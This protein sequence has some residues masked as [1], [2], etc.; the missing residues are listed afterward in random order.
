[1]K[2]LILLATLAA[3][4]APDLLAQTTAPQRPP[5]QHERPHRHRPRARRQKSPQKD[6]RNKD[7]SGQEPGGQQFEH[8]TF[9]EDNPG[10][11][12]PRTART[13]RLQVL[14]FRQN[15]HHPRQ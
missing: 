6:H 3:P 2:L 7:Q 8:G 9:P 1:M 14:F 12:R 5:P 15:P 13:R 11:H 10:H 4:V